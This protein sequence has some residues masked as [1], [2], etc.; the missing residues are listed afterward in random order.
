MAF[1]IC[2]IKLLNERLISISVLMSRGSTR[3]KLKKPR[4]NLYSF[5]HELV[6]PN[7]IQMFPVI[8]GIV[9]I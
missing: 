5:C 4:H 1:H 3:P 7:K 2:Q 8:A 6:D 9:P